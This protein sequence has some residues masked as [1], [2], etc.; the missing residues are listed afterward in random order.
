MW[1]SFYKGLRDNNVVCDLFHKTWMNAMHCGLL[2]EIKNVHMYS[3]VIITFQSFQIS[4]SAFVKINT[5]TV[6]NVEYR[7]V[8]NQLRYNHC[9]KL[10]KSSWNT[11]IQVLI[12]CTLC[13]PIQFST[14]FSYEIINLHLYNFFVI[15]NEIMIPPF[16]N[17]EFS[18]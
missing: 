5:S 2:Q 4:F 7:I 3:V 16:P 14:I 6:Y 15:R 9:N 12:I 10:V 13:T 1:F 11:K 18:L 8:I 17:L